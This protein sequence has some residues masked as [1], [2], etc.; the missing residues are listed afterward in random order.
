MGQVQLEAL[1]RLAASAHQTCAG[2]HPSLWT[3]EG[4]VAFGCRL[5]QGPTTST[6]ICP[7][8]HGNLREYPSLASGI[9]WYLVVSCGTG[10]L[11]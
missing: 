10:D 3:A 4:A 6:A 11:T 8:G 5:G 9:L 1:A 2:G 7:C